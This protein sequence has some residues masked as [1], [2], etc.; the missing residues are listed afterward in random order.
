MYWHLSPPRNFNWFVDDDFVQRDW[1]LV[2][3]LATAL[4]GAVLLAYAGR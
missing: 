1:P 4:Y 3:H 2:R